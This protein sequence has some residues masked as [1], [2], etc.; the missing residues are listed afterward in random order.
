MM[1]QDNVE[2]DSESLVEFD[3]FAFDPVRRVLSEQGVPVSLTAKAFDVL[4]ALI[5]N[6]DRVISR[7][8]I[9]DLVWPETEVEEGNLT[10]HISM[11]RKVLGEGAGENRFIVTVPGRG[12]R[13][14]GDLVKR[15]EP[16]SRITAMSAS[17]SET[18]WKW[19][20]IF[21]FTLLVALAIAFI[22]R[23]SRS[24]AKQPTDP[25]PVA[26]RSLAVLP[27]HTSGFETSDFGVA[28]ADGVILQLSGDPDLL[29]RPTGDVL[30]FSNPAADTPA[31]AGRQLGVDMVLSSRLVK[32]Q[33]VARLSVQMVRVSDGSTIWSA[34]VEQTFE[35]ELDLQDLLAVRIADDIREA[36]KP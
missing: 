22:T 34:Q 24:V 6:R 4:L 36:M 8:E 35:D 5:E 16:S 10:Q 28:L 32:A 21:A 15:S 14:V 2:R 3:R 20:A 1:N 31:E 27:F 25:L 13:F 9:M 11:L 7:T 23:D 18:T 12:Y 30:E 26:I 19:S 17:S 33:S 29:V